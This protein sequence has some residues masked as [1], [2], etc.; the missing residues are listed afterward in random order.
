MKNKATTTPI[1]E[2]WKVRDG[3]TSKSNP[4]TQSLKG[5]NLAKVA[6]LVAEPGS[7]PRSLDLQTKTCSTT[8]D[9]LITSKI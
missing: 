3:G 5:C 8:P 9:E 7:E 6:E 1:I 2:L 4:L